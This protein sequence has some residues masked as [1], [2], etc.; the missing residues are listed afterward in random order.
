M[1]TLDW[2]QIIVYFIALIVTVPL[3]GTYIAHVYQGKITFL[4]RLESLTYGIS[5][6]NPSQEMNWSTYAIS[7]LTF[8]C[9][10]FALLFLMLIG[11]YFLPLNPQHFPGLSLP[12]AFNA[13]VSFT[14]NTNWQAYTGEATLSYFSQMLGLTVQNFLSCATGVAVFIAFL[15]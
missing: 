13:A 1:S 2:I 10:G 9:L 6:I 3:L 15:R 4:R 8:N 14:T 5:G 11:Q 12:L 7:L